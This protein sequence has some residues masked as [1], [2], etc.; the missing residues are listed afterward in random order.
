MLIYDHVLGADPAIHAP[1]DR[2]YDVR[3]TFREPFVLFGYLAALTSLLMRQTVFGR[4]IFAI[5]SNELA[6]RS[7]DAL[8]DE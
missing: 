2:P 7:L 1:W 3:T 6:A 8:A 5:G 4:Y